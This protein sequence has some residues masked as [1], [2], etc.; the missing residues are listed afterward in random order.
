MRVKMNWRT[1]RIIL[2]GEINIWFML[3]LSIFIDLL[4]FEFLFFLVLCIALLLSSL[5]QNGL[6]TSAQSYC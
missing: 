6:K 5:S 1:S 2:L 4:N 3:H